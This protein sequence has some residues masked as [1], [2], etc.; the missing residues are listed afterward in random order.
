[1]RWKVIVLLRDFGMWFT[2]SLSGELEAIT[3][4]GIEI[5]KIIV[6]IDDDDH[7]CDKYTV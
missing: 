5:I 6:A 1:M 7:N 3:V 4:N 2:V